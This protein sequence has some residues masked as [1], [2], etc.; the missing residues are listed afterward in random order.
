KDLNPLVQFGDPITPETVE[1]GFNFVDNGIEEKNIYYY[2]PDHLGSSSHIT[3]I[4]GD[5]S[6]HTEFIAFGE[7]LFDEHSTSITMPYLFNSKELDSD[8][9]L[10]Y[11]GA[12]YYD[13]KVS[14][15]IN[16]DP[17]ADHPNQVDKSPYS[18]FWNNP[19]L[20]DDPDGQCPFCPWLDAVVDVG[21]VLYDVGVLVHEKVTTGKT[22]GANWVAL[23]ADGASIFVPMSVG[24]GAAVRA[25]VK[26]VNKADNA[27]DAVKTT[28]KVVENAKQGKQF[29]GVVTE[30][31]KQ[32]GHKNVAEQVT[33]KPN[34]GG[35]NVRLDNVST[36]DG[37]IK[38]T[39][40]KS[41]ATAP[42]TKNQKTGYPAIEKSGGTVVGNKGRDFGYPAG[43]KIPPTK[44][45]IVRPKD[46]KK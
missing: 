46:I 12:R 9:G 25:G 28:S 16:V 10:Y 26:A 29:E 6:Q 18:A 43:T 3:D 34:G 11:Y 44:V 5:L 2:H 22:S 4:N 19:I 41:S 13:P 21:F 32:T 37:Q 45:D 14:I 24:A 42:H 31:L 27:V 15:F 7:I 1:A 17:L 30:N 35:K 33:V 38:L 8:T 36:K 39:N 20:Y 40:A 23:G